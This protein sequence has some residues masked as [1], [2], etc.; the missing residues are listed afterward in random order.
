[1]RPLMP[2]TS[3]KLRCEEFDRW[4]ERLPPSGDPLSCGTLRQCRSDRGADLLNRRTRVRDRA[5][6]C[7]EVVDHS[8]MTDIFHRNPG[9]FE[10]V[11]VSLGLH[12]A[13]GRTRQ[14]GYGRPATRQDR[15]QAM[16]ITARRADRHCCLYSAG[17]TIP[18]TSPRESTPRRRRKK[19][20]FGVVPRVSPGQSRT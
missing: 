6:H 2:P 4:A 1:M 5:C 14:C 15:P 10:S 9:C 12:R 20:G 13:E 3:A 7:V 16:A 18:Q 17:K 11:R 19:E 8:A